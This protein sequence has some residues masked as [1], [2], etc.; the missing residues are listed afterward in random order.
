MLSVILYGRNDSH[1]YNLH[2]RAAISLNAIAHLLSDPDDEIVFVDYNT[3]DDLPTFP[4]AI[5]DTLTAKAIEKLRV[6]RIRPD[7][8]QTRFAA[9]THLVALEPIARNAAIRRT[10]P[11]NRWVLST[12]TDMIFAPRTGGDLTSVAAGLEDGFYHLPRF[13]LP[14]GLWE[15]LDRKDP[16]AIISGAREW[17]ERFYLNEIVHSGSDNL[18]DG[19]G[20]FQLFLRE[21]LFAIGGFHEEMIRGWHLD[22]NVARR[23]R[24]K[25]G[26]VSSALDRLVGYHCDHTRMA[27]AYHKADRV[28]NDPVRFVDEVTQA[29]IPEQMQTWGLPDVQIEELKLGDASG[30]RYLRALEAVVPGRLSG[31]LET[32]YIVESHGRLAYDL[33][34]VLPYLLDMVACIPQTATVGYVGLRRDT[35][36]AFAKGWEVM[37]GARPVLVPDTAPWL[38][39]TGARAEAAPIDCW[40]DETDF[41]IFE[42]GAEEAADQAGLSAAESAGLWSVDQAFKAAALRDQM[43]IVEGKAPRRAFVVNAIHNFFEPQILNSMAVTLTPFSSRIRHGY[44]GDRSASRSAGA[45]PTGRAAMAALGSLE[46]PQAIEVQRL[47]TLVRRLDP[48]TP[49]DPAWAEAGRAAAEIAAWSE[50]GVRGL[51][52][53]VADPDEIIHGVAA[54][55]PSARS[56]TVQDLLSPDAGRGADSRLIR[57]EDWDDPQWIALARTLFTNRDHASLFEREAWTWERVSLTANLFKASPPQSR[58]TVLVAGGQPERLAFVLAHMG[59]AVDIVDPE[60]LARGEPRANDWRGQFASEGWVAPRPVGLIDDRPADFLYDAVILPQ[61]SLFAAFRKGAGAVL[62]EAAARLRTGGHLGLS[63]VCQIF[64]A[65]GRYLEHGMPAALVRDGL[66]GR[67]VADLTDLEPTGATDGRLTQR[68][69]DRLREAKGV[70]GPPA[71]LTGVIPE[72]ETSG[73]WSFVKR[74]NEAADWKALTEVLREGR[75]EGAGPASEKAQQPDAGAAQSETFTADELASVAFGADQ[76]LRF[77]GLFSGLKAE[78]GVDHTPTALGVTA[79]FGAR[80]A[81]AADLGRLAPGA[82]ELAIEIQVR[83]LDQ[84]GPILAVGV[85][86]KSGLILEQIEQAA[87]PGRWSMVAEFEVGVDGRR[88]LGLAIKALGR[89]D[90]DILDVVLR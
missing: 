1:G 15:T 64:D 68:T 71:L 63:A 35:F 81:A 61:S 69:F 29:E 33:A 41:F 66:F 65:D 77:G 56:G 2:K 7:V 51:F 70:G 8:H 78:P 46:P 59:A 23:M 10:N 5:A 80:L 60:A 9:R 27:S 54:R 38:I 87:A 4:E 50:A 6:L 55:R 73:V 19:P 3:P 36:A 75:Y 86:G 62:Q 37:G 28:E 79:A 22:A 82:Y 67:A 72:V 47:N 57:L 34:H 88:G 24:I 74:P 43:R 48:K 18:Y 11:A 84:P 12:N 32:H 20:D 89:A 21:D 16:E 40:L 30:A 13:E 76:S 44:L 25:R 58:P 42:I 26:V 85:I 17:G 31:F 39:Q 90:L 49:A 52:E 45:V 53:G 83:R 14:E